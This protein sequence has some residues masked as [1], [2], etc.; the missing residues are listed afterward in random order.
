[1]CLF[2]LF[3]KAL[4]CYGQFL[5]LTYLHYFVG[6]VPVLN[7]SY[8]PQKISPKSTVSCYSFVWL[9]KKITYICCSFSFIILSNG[10]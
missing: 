5:C 6:E 7:V 8:K 3:H 1:M 9:L 4:Q 10:E 2:T